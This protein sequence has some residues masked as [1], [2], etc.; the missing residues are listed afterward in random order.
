M[1]SVESYFTVQDKKE[2]S[3]IPCSDLEKLSTHLPLT[4][5]VF[6]GILV[7]QGDEYFAFG[8]KYEDSIDQLWLG[9]LH[10]LENLG[11]EGTSPFVYQPIDF[12]MKKSEDALVIS[13]THRGTIMDEWTFPFDEAVTAILHGAEDFFTTVKMLNLQLFKD[14]IHL[15]QCR[16]IDLKEDYKKSSGSQ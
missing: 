1:I 7:I 8:E 13:I 4:Q 11:E 6:P 12:Y 14:D 2:K 9:L 5:P 15:I 3:W 10:S 16:I